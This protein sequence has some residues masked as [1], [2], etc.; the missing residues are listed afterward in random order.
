[1]KQT[2]Q[3]CMIQENNNQRLLPQNP[4]PV[5]RKLKRLKP[6]ESLLLIAEMD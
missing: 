4:Q 5:K 3:I 6:K 1:M 2:G